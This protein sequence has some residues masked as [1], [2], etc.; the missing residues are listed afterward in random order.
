MNT[1]P[2]QAGL[3]EKQEIETTTT[4]TINHQLQNYWQALAAYE[5]ISL[6]ENCIQLRRV[7]R[8][9]WLVPDALDSFWDYRMQSLNLADEQNQAALTNM[10]QQISDKISPE[11]ADRFYTFV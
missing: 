11:V 9:M 1:S 4:N 5:P 8:E 7:I 10:R 2:L 6:Y 3:T